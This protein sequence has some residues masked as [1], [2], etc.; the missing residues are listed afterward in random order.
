MIRAKAKLIRLKHLSGKH[1]QKTHARRAPKGGT[2]GRNGFWYA[3]G[4]WLP[5]TELPPGAFNK[6][7][8]AAKKYLE[9]KQEL[10]LYEWEKPPTIRHQALKPMLAGGVYTTWA[11]PRDK[12]FKKKLKLAIPDGLRESHNIPKGGKKEKRLLEMMN[13]WNNGERWVVWDSDERDGSFSF[14]SDLKKVES[15][16]KKDPMR[17]APG[18]PGKQLRLFKARR[19]LK[20]L[21]GKHDQKVHG[22]RFGKN[23]T[24]SRARAMK[25]DGNWGDYRKRAE[26]KKRP[27]KKAPAK[28]PPKKEANPLEGVGWDDIEW[29]QEGRYLEG[30]GEKQVGYI[31][32]TKTKVLMKKADSPYRDNPTQAELAT[33]ATADFLGM[34]DQVTQSAE[35]SRGSSI[36]VMQDGEVAFKYRDNR[37]MTDLFEDHPNLPGELRKIAIMDVVTGNMDRHRAN[38]LFRNNPDGSK[39]AMGID[40]DFAFDNWIVKRKQ[41]PG[42]LQAMRDTFWNW[43]SNG[44]A[45]EFN[46]Y[47]EPDGIGFMEKFKR[48][49][50]AP[51]IALKTNKAFEAMVVGKFGRDLW[52]RTVERIDFLEQLSQEYD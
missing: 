15:K 3:G 46:K 14:E 52:D 22:Y 21:A 12:Y 31:K 1:D 29:S 51:A 16:P 35:S 9:K 26:A 48:A 10:N 41:E 23:L 11:D 42:N 18:E 43:R 34:G 13:A 33:K 50:F 40:N 4:Q 5:S 25:R 24:L 27:S 45:R 7:K 39:T 36:Q 30:V 28:R 47:K 2:Y 8:V 17:P 44:M 37:A 6:K 32:G 20:H 19:K 49:D 38:V